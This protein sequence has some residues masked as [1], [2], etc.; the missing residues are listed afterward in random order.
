MSAPPSAVGAQGG[1]AR[2][3]AWALAACVLWSSAFVA[4]LMLPAH[5]ALAITGGRYLAFG[6]MALLALVP[7]FL[8]DRDRKA[9]RPQV[10]AAAVGLSLLGNLTYYLLL[11]FALQWAGAFLPSVIIGALP[12]TL[13][14]AGRA[15]DRQHGESIPAL[16]LP[17]LLVACGL[18]LVHGAEAALAAA[19][20]PPGD[21]GTTVSRRFAW[22]VAAACGAHLAWLLFGLLNARWLKRHRDVDAG[23][24]SNLLGVAL[25]PAALLLLAW[26]WPAAGAS[27]ALPPAPGAV[28]AQQGLAVVVDTLALPASAW[29][30]IV[31]LGTGML[32]GW[33]ATQCWVRASRLLPVALSAKLLVAETLFAMALAALWLGRWPAAGTLAGAGLLLGGVLIALLR[34]GRIGQA[35]QG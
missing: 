7:Y 27:A 23:L 10:W 17:L 13:A 1:R 20:E 34:F 35:A 29:F 31:T 21:G 16:G 32:S 8:G 5:G 12:L 28:A 25:L 22:G 26:D 9:L 14:L 15:L 18:A 30:W 33:G 24:W 6:A 19:A 2:G 11:V 3:V 4:P